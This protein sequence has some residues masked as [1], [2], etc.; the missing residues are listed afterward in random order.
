MNN[1]ERFADNDSNERERADREV[2]NAESRLLKLP[3]E[4]RNQIYSECLPQGTTITTNNRRSRARPDIAIL[5]V[6][7]AIRGEAARIFYGNNRFQFML[8]RPPSERKSEAE[9]FMEALPSDIVASLRSL[10]IIT[11]R[12][13]AKSC[14]TYAGYLRTVVRIDRDNDLYPYNVVFWPR[15]SLDGGID[16]ECSPDGYR[17]LLDFLEGM[18]L[19]DSQETLDKEDLLGL[20]S[21]MQNKER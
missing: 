1:K 15:E 17:D 16:C 4:L 11:R 5:G 13:C 9:E 3:A 18:N 12:Q 10:E 2:Q 7:R 19:D 14:G 6:S 21:V 20:V 8:W